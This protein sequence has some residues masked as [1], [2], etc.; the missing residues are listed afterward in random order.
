M[1]MV[2]PEKNNLL[3][4]VMTCVSRLVANKQLVETLVNTEDR[5]ALWSELNG[6]DLEI[7]ESLTAADIMK[8]NYATAH[9]EMTL[10]E[11]AV[12]MHEEHMDALPVVDAAGALIGD[13][14]ARKLFATCVPPYFSEM[15]SMRFARDFD[16]FEHFF[17]EKAHQA[18]SDVANENCPVIE[19]SAPLAEVIALLT[20]EGLTK[21]YVVKD[22]QLEGIIDNFS[23]IDKVLSI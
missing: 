16:A 23:I 9:P 8:Q 11:A 7:K 1:A 3:L 12:L 2:P 17:E 20:H 4:G 19:P 21:V 13:I 18:I 14:T 5:E 22:K 6:A 10:A 15:P